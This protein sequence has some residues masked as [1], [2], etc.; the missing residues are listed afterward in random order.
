MENILIEDDS[1]VVVIDKN[2]I[3]MTR[4]TQ[5][6]I[7]QQVAS[8]PVNQPWVKEDVTKMVWE[9]PISL[10]IA[11]T[12]AGKTT[13]IAKILRMQTGWRV[14]TTQPRVL[15]AIWNSQRVAQELLAENLD[16]KYTLN[17][18]EVWHRYAAIAHRG[19]NSM[20]SFNTGWLELRRQFNGLIPDITILDEAHHFWKDI[21]ILM[22]LY[23]TRRD[24]AKKLVIM[25]ATIEPDI[26]RDYFW[27]DFWEIPVLNIPWR[28]FPVEHF[29][30]DSPEETIPV[31]M[32]LL[33]QWK[34]W[35]FFVSWKSE[36]YSYMQK[37]R[38][39]GVEIPIY[40]LHAEL[41][42]EEQ[43]QAVVNPSK[44]QR[45]IIATNVAQESITPEWIQFVI[46]IGIHKVSYPNSNWIESLVKENISK[47]D[48]LQ[49]AGR[50]GRIEDGEYHRINEEDID[51]VDLYPVPPMSREMLDREILLFLN[52]WRD[53]KQ[54][55][56]DAE[57]KWE[58]LFAHEINRSLLPISY[59]RL[60]QIGAIN[61]RWRITELWRDL[62]SINLDVYHARMLLQSVEEWCVQE[63][64]YVVCILSTKWFLSTNDTWK[65]L[66]PNSW[67]KDIDIVF[68][69]G[70]LVDFSS[71]KLSKA[72]TNKYAAMW[73]SHTEIEAYHNQS[74]P[75]SER[76]MFFEMVDLDPIGVK[77]HKLQEIYNLIFVIQKRLDSL[78]VKVDLWASIKVWSPE[79][80]ER[81]A[82]IKK[83]VYAWY[84][85]FSARYDT[86][87]KRLSSGIKSWWI[88]KL[89]F[90]QAKTSVVSLQAWKDYTF[91]P[92]IL[93]GVWARGWDLHLAS[94]L[95]EIPQ[96]ADKSAAEF[97]SKYK[98]SLSKNRK[99]EI[100]C[101]SQLR[102]KYLAILQEIKKV[103]SAEDFLENILP[104]IVLLEN[105]QFKKFITNNPDKIEG[106]LQRLWRFFMANRRNYEHR[107][108]LTDISRTENSFR[109]DTS[110][111]WDFRQWESKYT[112]EVKKIQKSKAR[113]SPKEHASAQEALQIS[114]LRKEYIGLEW[115]YK[116]WGYQLDMRLL[117]RK[118]IGGVFQEFAANNAELNY[119]MAFI[120]EYIE[121]LNDEETK[122]ICSKLSRRRRQKISISKIRE[123]KRYLENVKAEL[124]RLLES[125]D[126]ADIDFIRWL[127]QSRFFKSETTSQKHKYRK[128]VSVLTGQS[129][130]HL[131]DKERTEAQNQL[132]GF[133]DKI[134]QH[135]QRLEREEDSEWK[136]KN[137][138]KIRSIHN[139]LSKL[140]RLQ[141]GSYVFSSEEITQL[142]NKDYWLESSEK[143]GCISVIKKLQEW[144]KE[145]IDERKIAKAK[146]YIE[147]CKN[148]LW[149]EID[150]QSVKI[151]VHQ[152]T[153]DDFDLVP[154]AGELGQCI[155]RFLQSVLDNDYYDINISEKDISEIVQTV[156]RNNVIRE[157]DIIDILMKYL[158][159]IWAI[160]YIQNPRLQA[161]LRLKKEYED[162]KYEIETS[163]VW[164]NW[165]TNSMLSDDLEEM[166]E[167]VEKFWE[168]ISRIKSAK[169]SILSMS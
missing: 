77:N 9:Y 13:Q 136:N 124:W 41:T 118:I 76:K 46:D 54:L 115:R 24:V 89:E 145:H 57:Q 97:I 157:F 37:L 96:D 100:E 39:A 51:Q 38:Q 90:Q 121:V 70:M 160:K 125:P 93:E 141:S 14:N 110:I 147:Q 21:E 161:F 43:V 7:L 16:P 53:L 28:T 25:S 66:L 88:W 31:T 102:E 103:K 94:F 63:M 111:Y 122:S 148:K 98:R 50:A 142:E 6:R 126:E 79:F 67:R 36:I 20:L 123:Y 169:E 159:H 35:L 59:N 153:Y 114:Q 48:S 30:H 143:K 40:P 162:V 131:S 146:G 117:N 87:K 64:I 8:L 23:K 15:A 138:N 109:H 44:E 129:F 151:S 133:S 58:W 167:L 27:K 56:H 1:P 92:F 150:N 82:W 105:H 127:I 10:L 22:W 140:Q 139:L 78:G 74:W 144:R 62:L 33:E 49:R 4:N 152:R 107:V 72:K 156:Y 130:R 55:L 116:S 154:K 12:G 26:F 61:E 19:K 80:K 83:C 119:L 84:P 149:A 69:I 112:Q 3:P 99:K 95:S 47:A 137:R 17:F 75:V 101:T 132:S 5:E 166:Q 34:S 168:K 45:L 113:I 81:I 60:Q 86:W 11:E 163:F 134:K 128:S 85:F 165:K 52:K 104:Y 68:Y 164:S 155:Q 71:R 18:W 158:I 135:K 2:G 32:K 106:M 120:K 29:Y 91:Y 65:K 108:N 73:I 42:E